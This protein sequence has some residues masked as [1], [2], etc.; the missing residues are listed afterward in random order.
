MIK[1]GFDAD[2]EMIRPA[3]TGGAEAI[4]STAGPMPTEKSNGTVSFSQFH[5]RI[6][7]GPSI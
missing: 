6:L 5:H 4:V 7:G 2:L 1:G 3:I